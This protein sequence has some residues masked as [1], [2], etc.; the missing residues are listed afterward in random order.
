M[1]KILLFLFILMFFSF[2]SGLC[3]EGQININEA[4][5]E[6]LDEL[7]GI[8]PVK[9]QSIIDSRAFES[10]D[11]LIDVY[12]IGEKTLEGIKNQGLACVENEETEETESPQEEKE[13]EIQE[14]EEDEEEEET[15]EDKKEEIKEK[16]EIIQTSLK[17]SSKIT[18]NE[19]QVI[20]I[21]P[22]DIKTEENKKI[23]D[24][25]KLAIYGL[26][27]FCILLIVLFVFN[28]KRYKNEFR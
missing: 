27:L 16:S 17:E 14:D 28:K 9:A 2:I 8:G 13:E 11:N 15:R 4:S 20:T 24:T 5:L 26:V 7:Y 6:E 3:N 23:L 19:V 10:V 22:K 25:N 1:N 12:G 18:G 21:N